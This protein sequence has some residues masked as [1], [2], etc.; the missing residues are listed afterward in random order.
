M[1]CPTVAQNKVDLVTEAA[2]LNQHETIQRFIQVRRSGGGRAPDHMNRA[3][4]CRG[5]S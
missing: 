1:R 5:S 3:K 2:A 4:Q